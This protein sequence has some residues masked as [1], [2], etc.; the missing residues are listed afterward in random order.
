MN[1]YPKGLVLETIDCP[2]CGNNQF[3]YILNGHDLL[4]HIEGE[5]T[6]VQCRRCDLILTNPRPT[7]ESIGIYYPEEYAP[8]NNNPIL[9]KQHLL[10]SKIKRFLGLDQKR[11]P[12]KGGVLY[13]VGC[14]NGNYL[15]EMK[16]SNWQIAGGLEYSAYSA[17][18]ARIKGFDIETNSIENAKGPKI[19]VDI[20]VAWM[21]IEH[22]HN[23][24]DALQ[25]MNQWVKPE[26]YLVASIPFPSIFQKY[27]FKEL[28]Y[29]L[30]LPTHLFHYS[31]HTIKQILEKSNWKLVTIRYQANPM[32][33]LKSLRYIAIEKKWNKRLQVI[34]FIIDHPRASK[35]RILVGWLLKITKQ[36]G[37]VEFTAIPIK[38][39]K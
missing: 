32:T 19:P 3:E 24:I 16:L 18:L 9:T 4:H 13:E 37:R 38:T 28:S 31:L 27:W 26:G 12:L 1:T 22:L 36:S 8:Y 34:N 10:I 33:F 14:A 29:D 21:L 6:I 25:K 30:Q 5:F 15:Q 20:I 11:L 23:P 2:L 39:N 7:P 17:N 35:I